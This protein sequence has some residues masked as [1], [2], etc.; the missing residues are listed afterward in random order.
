MRQEWKKREE[1]KVNEMADFCD[2][3]AQPLKKMW[4]QIYKWYE[5]NVRWEHSVVGKQWDESAMR[6]RGKGGKT[7]KWMEEERQ[8]IKE[9]E[10]ENL[11]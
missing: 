9:A 10:W 6:R 2:V 7:V 1:Q 3:Q 4:K 11:H 5:N 8:E